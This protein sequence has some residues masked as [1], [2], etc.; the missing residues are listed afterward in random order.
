MVSMSWAVRIQA[1]GE[2]LF[3]ER[4]RTGQVVDG[5]IDAPSEILQNHA[6]GGCDVVECGCVTRRKS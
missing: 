3:I 6:A 1:A 5:G 2:H 4:G